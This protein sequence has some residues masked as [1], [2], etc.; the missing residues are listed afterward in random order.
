MTTLQGLSFEEATRNWYK[1]GSDLEALVTFVAAKSKGRPID[2][3]AQHP[4]RPRLY[5]IGEEIFFRRS[6]P[7]D[8]ACATCHSQDDKRIRLQE[9]P[10]L[11]DGQGRAVLHV[12]MAGLSRVAERGVDHGAAPDRLHAANALSR[13]RLPFRCGDRACR[14]TCRRTPAARPWKRRA[15]SAEERTMRNLRH[16]LLLGAIAVLPL[17]G[18][19]AGH[20]RHSRAGLPPIV[21][22]RDARRVG[23][24]PAAGRGQGAVQQVPQ[25]SAAGGGR[26]HPRAVRAQHRA[27]G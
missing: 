16:A 17:A 11:T 21:L 20:E 27:A 26:A 12:A 6:G 9:L 22:R 18:I 5:A 10:N 2:V 23:H 24:T 1:S 14:C 19:R 4:R 13:R 15:S 7:L 25:P 3:P 8:F